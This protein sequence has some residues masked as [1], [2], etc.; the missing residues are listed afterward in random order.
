MR[1]RARLHLIKEYKLLKHYK[2]TYPTYKSLIQ[3]RQDK[4]EGAEKLAESIGLMSMSEIIELRNKI[5]SQD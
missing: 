1:T 5:L 3:A 2:E 4:I